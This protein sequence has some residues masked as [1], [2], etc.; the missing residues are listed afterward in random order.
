MMSKIWIYY[1]FSGVDLI[2]CKT[3]ENIIVAVYYFRIR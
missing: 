3:N 2:Y 1:T